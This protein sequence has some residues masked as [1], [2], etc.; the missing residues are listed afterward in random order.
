MSSR[1]AAT[2][3][4]LYARNLYAF[5][6]SLTDRHADKLA[7]DFDDEL[8]KATLLIRDGRIVHSALTSWP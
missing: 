3:S 2:V 5:L 6:E 4:R 8:V 7:I 1:I